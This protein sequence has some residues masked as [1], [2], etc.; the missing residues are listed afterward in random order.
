MNPP[1]WELFSVELLCAPIQHPPAPWQAKGIFGVGGLQD[2]GFSLAW[3]GQDKNDPRTP[4]RS[5]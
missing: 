3:L 4:P 5:C 2:V 1:D